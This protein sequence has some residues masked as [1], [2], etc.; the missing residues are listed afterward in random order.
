[1]SAD[2]W[3]PNAGI[4]P[5]HIRAAQEAISQYDSE[6]ELGFDQRNQTWVVLWSNG[7]DGAPY[8]VLGLGPSLPTYDEIQRL[9]YTHDTRRH[10]AKIVQEVSKRNEARKAAGRYELN[11]AAGEVAEELEHAFRRMGK[12]SYKKIYLPNKDF[13]I[14]P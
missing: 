3:L 6:L 7:P 12:T 2:L 10:G 11:Q 5:S 13:T 1:M 14:A 4:V 9:L 8:P